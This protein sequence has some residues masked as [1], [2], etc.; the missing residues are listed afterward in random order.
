[1]LHIAPEHA[2]LLCILSLLSTTIPAVVLPRDSWLS[3]FHVNIQDNPGHEPRDSLKEINCGPSDT[4]AGFGGN[5]VHLITEWDSL[6]S[7]A[8]RDFSFHKVS[9]N[10]CGIYIDECHDKN[11]AKGM[12]GDVRYSN[13]AMRVAERFRSRRQP[14]G[15]EIQAGMLRH[16]DGGLSVRI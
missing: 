6:K 13:L 7:S 1:F 5:Y 4:N 14:C 16:Q 8:I 3:V 15:E 2:D 11:L 9:W 10:M 12:E